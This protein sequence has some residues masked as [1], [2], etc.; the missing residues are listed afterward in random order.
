MERREGS[1]AQTKNE[2]L[3]RS[4]FV[5]LLYPSL[6]SLILLLRKL[7]ILSNP[8]T[9]SNHQRPLKAQ[10]L[11]S[12]LDELVNDYPP[13]QTPFNQQQPSVCLHGCQAQAVEA[14]VGQEVGIV[15]D[16]LG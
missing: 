9:T 13:S 1:K 5:A 12:S 11:Q 16:R 3:G 10:L 7:V 8:F 15:V 4:S 2:N 6:L 14:V